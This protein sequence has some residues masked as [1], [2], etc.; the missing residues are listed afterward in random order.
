MSKNK[1]NNSFKLDKKQIGIGVFAL[2][3]LALIFFL[4]KNIDF[5]NNYGKS[6]KEINENSYNSSKIMRVDLDDLKSID[7]DLNT[8]DVRIQKSSTNPY[9]EYTNLYRDDYSYEVK[10]KFKDGNLKLSS[11]IKGKEL[12]MKNKIQIV[13][14]F[15][16]KNKAIESIKGRVGAGDIKISDL[17]CKD[18]DL[19]L[20][21]G[22][23]SF[24]KSKITGSVTNDVGSILFKNSEIKD[25]NL[26]TRVG[27]IILK[28]SKLKADQNLENENGDIEISTKD[29]IK[30]FNI[31]AKLNV[32]NFVLGNVSYRNI[33]D[34][35]STGKDKNKSLNMKTKIGDIL[36]NKGEGSVMKDEDFVTSPNENSND[37]STPLDTDSNINKENDNTK[38]N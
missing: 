5:S 20:E 26:K 14:I 32:G 29:S 17:N 4:S 1:K 13:R 19:N 21:S 12:Y 11:D 15:L 27:N 35:Y 22:N 30:S 37:L 3:I 10:T 23:I 2:I 7:F 9:V 38:N 18:M 16:P 28:D 24:N 8:C 36:I 33:L 31:N 25:T 34:G 6:S